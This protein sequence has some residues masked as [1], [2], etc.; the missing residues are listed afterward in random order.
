[1]KV[2]IKIHTTF[3]SE[4]LKKR[5]NFRGLDVCRAWVDLNTWGLKLCTGVKQFKT[6]WGTMKCENLMFFLVS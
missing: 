3:Q 6:E 2:E 5:D 1:V 4:S